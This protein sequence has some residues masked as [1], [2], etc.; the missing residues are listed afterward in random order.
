MF[1]FHLFCPLTKTGFERLVRSVLNEF[2][3]RNFDVCH[4]YVEK[5]VG[6]FGYFRRFQEKT[7][8][9]KIK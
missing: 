8:K 4:N 5:K 7:N 2:A 1:Y 6:Q 3:R 9:P